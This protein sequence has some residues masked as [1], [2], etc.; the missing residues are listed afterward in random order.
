MRKDG[1]FGGYSEYRYGNSQSAVYNPAARRRQLLKGQQREHVVGKV[2]TL[3]RQ[4]TQS[5]FEYEG[6]C[7]HSIR[8]ALCLLGYR[9]QVSDIEAEGIVQE[10]LNRIGAKRPTWAEGQPYYTDARENC[11]NCG[12]AIR[13]EDYGPKAKFCSVECASALHRRMAAQDEKLSTGIARIAKD[14][15]RKARQPSKKCEHCERTFVPS[16]NSHGRFCSHRCYHD[17]ERVPTREA[18]CEWCSKKFTATRSDAKFCSKSCSE[19]IGQVRRGKWLPKQ[20]SGPV[21]DF[22]YT[23]P[24]NASRPAWLT[25]ERF[26]EMVAA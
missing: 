24:I 1:Y 12:N 9:W 2:E 4:W 10:A 14:T 6:T 16:Y 26:D 17:H 21:F 5:K 3:L 22:F 19:Q 13:P 18:Q 23:V 7:R 8:E 25:P 15:V 11:I 20:L